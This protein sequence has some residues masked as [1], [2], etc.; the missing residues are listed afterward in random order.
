[1]SAPP[2][3]SPRALPPGSFLQLQPAPVLHP[4]AEPG[5]LALGEAAGGGDRAHF[6]GLE[7]GSPARCRTRSEAP[8]AR[9]AGRR[10]SIRRRARR[11]TR[12]ARHPAASA[13]TA[14]RSSGSAIAVEAEHHAFRGSRGRIGGRGAVPVRRPRP[15]APAPPRRAVPASDC[16]GRS[17]QGRRIARGE[18][19]STSAGPPRRCA[20]T[21]PKLRRNLRNVR[22]PVGQRAEVEPGAADDHRPQPARR[23]SAS[24]A[25]RREAR[26]RPN[27]A[28]RRPRGRTAHAARA[29]LVGAG[30]RRQH[31]P[32]GVDLRR[33]GVDHAAAVALGDAQRQRRLAAGGGP[34]IRTGPAAI[35]SVRSAT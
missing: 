32:A 35:A 34:S 22:R 30:P 5:A 15:V 29:Q 2:I 33:V 23:A 7:V 24:A 13:G 25:A 26:R 17:A 19:A 6:S 14:G 4:V 28:C 3:K 1:M 16:R 20:S 9:D 8:S 27:T 18:S 11:G 10:E 12:P 31:A 21:G